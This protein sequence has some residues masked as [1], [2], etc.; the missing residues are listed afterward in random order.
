[1]ESLLRVKI[2]VPTSSFVIKKMREIITIKKISLKITILSLKSL[3]SFRTS[4][5]Y[6]NFFEHVTNTFSETKAALDDDIQQNEEYLPKDLE[7][8]LKTETTNI[9]K[10]RWRKGS[11]NMKGRKIEHE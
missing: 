10:K 4:I 5:E 11:N 2:L 6:L 8:R 9:R 1:M 7:K 3:V